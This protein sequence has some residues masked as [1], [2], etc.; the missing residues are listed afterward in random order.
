MTAL[1]FI[2]LECQ[3]SL[4]PSVTLDPCSLST[5]GKLSHTAKRGPH[6]STSQVLSTAYLS[7]DFSGSNGETMEEAR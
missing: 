6:I 4:M 3:N 7:H 2:I 5:V 1:G